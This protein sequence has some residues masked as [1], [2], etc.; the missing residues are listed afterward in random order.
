M[1]RFRVP[2]DAEVEGAHRLI[3]KLLLPGIYLF[4]M[5]L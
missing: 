1:R 5:D 3:L 2:T 4:R